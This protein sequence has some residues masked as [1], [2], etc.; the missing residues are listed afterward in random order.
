VQLATERI[1]KEVTTDD[2]ARLV[3]R[4]LDQVKKS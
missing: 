3:D 2:Q 1:K 4:Y